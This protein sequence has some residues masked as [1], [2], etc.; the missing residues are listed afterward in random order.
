MTTTTTSSRNAVATLLPSPMKR[1]SISLP[2]LLSTPAKMRLPS[3]VKTRF[4]SSPSGAE[5]A[6]VI[7]PENLT[8]CGLCFFSQMHRLLNLTRQLPLFKLKSEGLFEVLKEE[9]SLMPME[10]NGCGVPSAIST[11]FT[12][13]IPLTVNSKF[14]RPCS[15][16]ALVRVGEVPPSPPTTILSKPLASS[17]PSRVL[18]DESTSNIEGSM[19]IANF[20]P[21]PEGV[22]RTSRP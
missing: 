7:T 12:A 21:P 17:V 1:H 19:L 11:C 13:V 2:S 10:G 20:R 8:L 14:Q 5:A 3:D 9:M 6:L 4:E 18:L 15:S 22:L 16:S